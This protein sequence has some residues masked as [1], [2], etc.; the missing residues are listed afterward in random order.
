M[1]K[2]INP[3]TLIVAAAVAAM[4]FGSGCAT[5]PRQSLTMQLSHCVNSLPSR[6]QA[7]RMPTTLAA[8][9][10][11][12]RLGYEPTTWH[13]N[14]TDTYCRR[15]TK[16]QPPKGEAPLP[17]CFNLQEEADMLTPLNGPAPT[18]SWQSSDRSP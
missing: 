8:S 2:P 18:R 4:L 9:V 13:G 3:H 5:A 12:K 1:S 11:A 7:T 14:T 16:Q 15:Q 10:C 17:V 6:W